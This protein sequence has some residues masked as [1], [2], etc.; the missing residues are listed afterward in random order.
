MLN[1]Q[2]DPA[3]ITKFLPSGTEL[4][5]WQGR[6]FVSLV[7]FRF[8]NTRMFSVPVLFHRDFDEI[9]LRIYVRRREGNAVKRGV[10]FIREI[11][12]RQAVTM[13][14]RLAYNEQY[15]TRRMSHRIERGDDEETLHAQYSWV[16]RR[17]R[18]E[19]SVS[20]TG[21]PVLPTEGSLEQYI[22]EHYW[23]YSAQRDGGCLEY[24]VEH[25]PWHVWIAREARFAGEVGDLYDEDLAGIIRQP[26][27]SALLAEGSRVAVF[28]GTRIRN[29]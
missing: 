1:Y 28:R 26:P 19:L 27:A 11:V 12:N 16:G 13:I 17:D 8:L 14:A 29:P 25:P 5:Q 6:N 10:A 4:D 18:G 3:L 20:V 23:G 24:R 21:D 9:N 7:G 15:V 2:V 22:A